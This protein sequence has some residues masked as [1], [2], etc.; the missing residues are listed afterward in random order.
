MNVKAVGRWDG[1]TAAQQAAPATRPGA[2]ARERGRGNKVDYAKT[3]WV[4]ADGRLCYDE[5]MLKS[6]RGVLL[7]FVAV[8]VV[9]SL[10][11]LARG[12]AEAA[13][14]PWALPAAV[15]I[16]LAWERV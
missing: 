11:G 13:L 15:A 7:V 2:F 16:G 9:W 1:G 12:D 14:L 4:D 5:G 6:H 8:A 10:A 3:I